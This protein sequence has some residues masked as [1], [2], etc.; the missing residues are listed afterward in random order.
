MTGAYNAVAPNPVTNTVFTR[1]LGSA[2]GRPSLLKVPA[3]AIRLALGQMG[4]RLRNLESR[5]DQTRLKYVI[6]AGLVVF[7]LLA[8]GCISVKPITP[9]EPVDQ[10]QRHCQILPGTESKRR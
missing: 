6:V 10:G 8:L 7:A 1:A 9:S 5:V 3:F 2:L 4:F